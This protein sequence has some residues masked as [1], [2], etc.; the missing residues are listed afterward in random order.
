[1]K[2]NISLTKPEL[3]T[4]LSSHYGFTVVDVEL[5]QPSTMAADIRKTIEQFDYRG[6]QKIAAIKALRQLGLDQKWNGGVVI[7]LADAK[8]IIEHFS[9]FI[10]F[11][12]NNN[13][14][15]VI[16]HNGELS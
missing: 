4:I 8:W 11:V 2:A 10:A 1:M 15:P 6:S 9:D 16:G 5:I 12:E 13:R 7:G 14:L 3:L